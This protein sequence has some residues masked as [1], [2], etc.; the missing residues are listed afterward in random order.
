MDLPDKLHRDFYAILLMSQRQ[1]QTSR[2]I[3]WTSALAVLAMLCGLAALFHRWVLYPV[4][5]LQRGV[6]RVARG[7]FDYKIDLKTGD[8]MQGLAEA[9]NDM[10]ARLSVTY[11]DLERQVQ[12]RSRQL[13]RSERLAGVGFLA[14]GVAHE[15]NNPLASIAFCS[16]AL[17]NRLVPLLDRGDGDGESATPRSS[18]TTCG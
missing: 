11:A 6:R 17:E 3:V 1:Y 18:A 16:E 9:F 7:Q 15:I 8:E 4:R 12:E 5:L 14:A 13:V 2:V 10:T